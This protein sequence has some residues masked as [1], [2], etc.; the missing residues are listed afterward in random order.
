LR[1]TN[2]PQ[3]PVDKRNASLF[4]CNKADAQ[5]GGGWSGPGAG[6]EIQF[7]QRFK[8][9]SPKYT[10][11]TRITVRRFIAADSGE[12]QISGIFR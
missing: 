8:R 9:L 3:Q 10:Y 7:P 2:I 11:V 1:A 6:T 12:M 5:F 4:G